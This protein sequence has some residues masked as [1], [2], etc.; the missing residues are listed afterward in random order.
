LFFALAYAAWRALRPRP[1]LEISHLPGA[2]TLLLAA[3]GVALASFLIRLAMPTGQSIL[4]LQL[5]Y[6]P[7]YVLL[8][9]V[10]CMAARARVLEQ[11]TRAQA[12][13]W[14]ILSVAM[15]ILF[16]LVYAGRRA[17]GS[18][19]GGWS[20]NAAFYALW[21]PLTAWG[22]TLGLLWAFSAYGAKA[23]PM[24]VWLARGA[25]G[26]YIV[27]PPIVVALSLMARAW[28]VSPLVKFALVGTAACMGS[29][30]LAGAVLRWPSARRIL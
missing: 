1:T 4:G 24:T 28:A 29:F 6:F 11:V 26:A 16:A 17:Q 2:T 8:F 19:S 30:A 15:V 13:P 12:A 7:P 22:I 20:V 3:L 10:G 14:A 21:D 23:I 27:H 18:F 5:G 9:V 25:Y